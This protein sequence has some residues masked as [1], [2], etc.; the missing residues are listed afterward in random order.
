MNVF[1]KSLCAAVSTGMLLGAGAFSPAFAQETPAPVGV[2]AGTLANMPTDNLSLT[3][4][5]F[6]NNNPGTAGNGTQLEDTSG[7]GAALQ[8]A[9]FK[10]EKVNGIDLSTQAGWIEAEKLQKSNGA[11][12]TYTDVTSGTTDANGELTFDGLPIGLYRVTETKAPEGHRISAAPFFVALPMTDPVELNDWMS[13]VHVYPKN[14]KTADQGT[15][16][17]NDAA[18]AIAGN[19]IQYTIDQPLEQRAADAPARTQYVISDF[20]PADRLEYKS[21]NIDGYTEGT[22]YNVDTNTAG[23]AQIIFT[24]AGRAKVDEASRTADAAIQANLTFEVLDP[25]NTETVVNKFKVSE[26]FA[27]DP[28]DPEDPTDPPTDPEDPEDPQWPKSYFGS[29]DIAKVNSE[30]TRLPGAEFDLYR[31]DS[32]AALQGEALRSGIVADDTAKPEVNQ[33]RVN[34]WANNAVVAEND[35]GFYCLVETK[36]PA[37]YELNAQPIRFQVLKGTQEA[38]IAL[39]SVN[40]TDVE[41]NAGFQLPLTGGQGILILLLAGGALLII[42]RGYALYT[43]RKSA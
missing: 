31:C 35:R 11:G 16:T 14:N 34:D 40:V 28:G 27:G 19:D 30:G 29:V 3:I 23:I 33:L 18:T 42:G 2:S 39:T 5:K 38:S 25:E 10:L 41:D 6:A 36:A 21:I 13:N 37:G 8:G 24:E 32:K 17:V 4:H 43:Q 7:L 9:Q 22:D 1:K 15:K 12:A 20:Y 26:N